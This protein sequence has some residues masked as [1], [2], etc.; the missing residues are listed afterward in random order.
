MSLKNLKRVTKD[1]DIIFTSVDDLRVFEE[2]LLALGYQRSEKVDNVYTQ[3]GAYS[4]L[5]HK[6]KAGFD[7][8][9]LQVCNMLILSEG[10]IK[11]ASKYSDMG[12]LS[13]YLISNED[14]S[15]FKAITERPR[16]IDD[17]YVLISA[18][19]KTGEFDWDAIKEECES[20]AE[21]LKIEGHLYERFNELFSKYKIKAPLMSWL[22]KRDIKNILHEAYKIR[23]EKGLRHDDILNEFEKEGFSKADLKI[24]NGFGKK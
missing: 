20:Q 1:V 24:L 6:E 3:L 7:L 13:I 10:M 5:R 18:S 19:Q 8:F 17:I 11:R 22:R 16:D 15:L 12:H 23:I 4:I 14:I 21:Q 9:Y 2:E